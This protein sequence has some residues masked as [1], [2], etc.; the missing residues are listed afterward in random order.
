MPTDMDMVEVDPIDVLLALIRVEE[1]IQAWKAAVVEL[2]RER[3]PTMSIARGPF[4]GWD[5]IPLPDPGP[6]SG[7][8]PDYSFMGAKPRSG[9]DDFDIGI[10]T[11]QVS[12]L[13][14]G[15]HYGL[16]HDQGGDMP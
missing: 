10:Y 7:C 8:W 5:P 9:C 13:F 11:Q 14:M 12:G 15:I 2:V 6:F 1:S 4:R 3:A 16:L